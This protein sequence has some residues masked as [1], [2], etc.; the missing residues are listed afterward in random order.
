M[1]AAPS[2]AR[3]KLSVFQ[4]ALLV[5]SLVVITALIADAVAPVPKE[6]SSIIQMLDITACVLFF[7]DF[8]IRFARAER[9]TAFMKW[10]WI[11]LIACIPNVD[12]LRIGR[13]VRVLRIIR[14]LRGVRVGHRIISIV[15]QN[16][17]KTA[18][19]GVLLTT[20]L[21]ITFSA[22]SILIAE[23]TA[24]ANIKTAEDAIWWS[25]TTITTVGYGDK[26]PMSTEGRLIAMVL[27]MSG[28][29]LFGMLSGL[30]ASFF[31]GKQEQASPELQET[32]L[33]LRSIEQKLNE[34]EKDSIGHRQTVQT[35]P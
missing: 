2:D 14:L 31:L 12:M 3:E 19:A 17:P 9:K 6:V 34:R 4:L 7:V 10:G 33:R 11:D 23:D 26:F 21:L 13:M 18:F 28:V 30:V 5:M 1:Q 35:T 29:G 16:K 15:L 27:M 20:L 24:E 22:I 32:F 25:V 8:C